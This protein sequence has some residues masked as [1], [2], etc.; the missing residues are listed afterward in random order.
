M[1]GPKNE[2]LLGSDRDDRGYSR[3]PKI[4]RMTSPA[5]RS[6]QRPWLRT[7]RSGCQE[8]IIRIADF[9]FFLCS[10]SGRRTPKKTAPCG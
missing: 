3:S 2:P 9:A 1:K 8:L 7:M 10:S 6:K 5:L 4:R